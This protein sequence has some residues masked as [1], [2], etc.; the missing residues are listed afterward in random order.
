M[1]IYILLIQ[2]TAQGMDNVKNS[3]ERLDAGRKLFEDH[4]AKI[5]AFYLTMGQYDIVVKAE[6]PD[7]A[8]MAKIVLALGAQGNVKT[9]TLRAFEEDEYRSIVASI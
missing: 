2:Y 4:G 6:A 5:L 9:E 8:T 7:D 3:P 1:S